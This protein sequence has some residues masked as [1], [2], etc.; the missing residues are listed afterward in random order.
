MEHCESQI[1]AH[2]V[3]DGGY[4]VGSTV[5]D[6]IAAINEAYQDDEYLPRQ[7]EAAAI[8]EWFDTTQEDDDAGEWKAARAAKVA[9]LAEIDAELDVEWYDAADAVYALVGEDAYE[10]FLEAHDLLP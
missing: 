7:T 8:Y 1:Q 5:L 2:T 10:A 3:D 9:R 4:G 6:Q